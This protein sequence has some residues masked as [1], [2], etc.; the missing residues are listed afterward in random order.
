MLNLRKGHL[1]PILDIEKMPKGQSM[2][3]LKEGL[4]NWLTI[5]EKP[6]RSKTDNLHG[7]KILR[8]F[9]TRRFSKITNFG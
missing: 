5:V 6:L 7:R 9:S 1:P 3:K 8:R 4:Q 2:N